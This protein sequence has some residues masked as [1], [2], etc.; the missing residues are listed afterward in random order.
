MEGIEEK[1]LNE[2]ATPPKI[3]KRFIDDI[4]AT[5]MNKDTVLTFI[6]RTK[7]H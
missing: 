5:I 7:Q 6:Q 3:W 1:A 4:Y 2:T